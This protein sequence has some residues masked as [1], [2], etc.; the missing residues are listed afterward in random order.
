MEQEQKPVQPAEKPISK[1]SIIKEFK[2][3][4]ARGS[5]V[6]MAVGLIVGSAFTAIVKSLVDDVIM[7]V[8]GAVLTGI[9]F[10][11][12]GITIPWGDRPFIAI[13]SFLQAII[14]FLIT[15]ACVFTMVKALNKFSRKKKEAPA[16]PKISKEEE[17]LTEIRDLLK[18][19]N[20]NKES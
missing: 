11:S 19:Q 8:I 9:N 5:V 20:Q 10:H 4:I 12:I 7:P 17:L 6:D 3:F 13:G 16:L 2:E 18:A 14:V 1:T 15:A